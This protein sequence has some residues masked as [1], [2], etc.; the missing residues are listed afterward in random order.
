MAISY[1]FKATDETRPRYILVVYDSLKRTAK[2]IK[3]DKSLGRSREDTLHI[4][5]ASELLTLCDDKHITRRL[6]VKMNKRITNGFDRWRTVCPICGIIQWT[7][8]DTS[9]V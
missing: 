1:E 4:Q 8:H 2:T 3:L 5:K 9:K 6:V 7:T